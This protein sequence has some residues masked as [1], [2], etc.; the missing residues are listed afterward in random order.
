MYLHAHHSPL[1]NERCGGF[2]TKNILLRQPARNR[3]RI[4]LKTVA[5][6][7]NNFSNYQSRAMAFSGRF[8]HSLFSSSPSSFFL[9]LLNMNFTFGI[10]LA[11]SRI[12]LCAEMG[13]CSAL[14]Q[15]PKETRTTGEEELPIQR[16]R[17]TGRG[18]RGETFG[19][20]KIYYNVVAWYFNLSCR[21]KRGY[22]LLFVLFIHA[23][24]G[25]GNLFVRT[26]MQDS[27][28]YVCKVPIAHFVGLQCM[29]PTSAVLGRVGR[30]ESNRKWLK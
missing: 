4:R 29:V 30:T 5:V 9:L 2:V 19:N 26:T 10:P 17:S 15:E 27:T 18:L 8:S 24:Y 7:G 25:R 13:R 28:H 21:K 22:L 23:Q 1:C 16:W 20:K 6:L 14:S 11:V 3:R 12:A